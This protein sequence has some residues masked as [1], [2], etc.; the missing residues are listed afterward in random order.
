MYSKISVVSLDKFPIIKNGDKL[1]AIILNCINE[2]KL[3][4]KNGDILCIA[5]KI[6]SKAEGC[7]YSLNDIKPSKK[8]LKISDKLNK[9][10]RKV[11]IILR[12]S[13]NIIRIFKHKNQNEGVII[14]EH[15]LGFISANAAVDESNTGE[16][17]TII[18]LPKNPDLSA[19][20]IGDYIYQKLNVSVGVVITD[21]FGRPWRLG[22]VNV[23]IGLSKVPATIDEKGKSDISGRRL[24]VTEPAFADEVAAASGLVIK[25]NSN[26][27]VVIISG[28]NWRQENSNSNDLLRKVEEDM[29]RWVLQ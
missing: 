14:C 16:I 24:K 23:A 25:K 5:Q 8:A 12:E 27:P 1:G 18:T 9:D 26:T 13:K 6:V 28:L 10:P 17:D 22:Q 29:F 20:K 3:E 15:K 11:E 7:I 4:L 19:S 2:N 21:T